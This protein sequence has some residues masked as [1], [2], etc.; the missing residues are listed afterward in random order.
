M[1]EA[2]CPLCKGKGE[3]RGIFDDDDD[4][5]IRKCHH[6]CHTNYSMERL[7]TAIGTVSKV[8]KMPFDELVE[9]M[10]RYRGKEISKEDQ[11]DWF[12]TGLNN[13]DFFKAF[14]DKDI[15][16]FKRK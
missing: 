2:D 12:F 6:S 11:D 16:F 14:R 8:N 13:I 15:S 9:K 1:K 5:D 7:A 10:E 4:P 3:I